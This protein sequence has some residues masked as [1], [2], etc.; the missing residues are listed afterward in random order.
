MTGLKYIHQ[1]T[2]A[3][4]VSTQGIG[5]HSGDAVK[6]SLLPAPA[7]SGVI[8][9]RTDVKNESEAQVFADFRAVSA[10]MLGTTLTNKFGVEVATIEHL[11]AAL[12]GMEIDNVIVEVNSAEMP[13]M[14]GSSA[15]FV[16]MIMRAGVK[17]QDTPRQVLKIMQE[18]RVGDKQKYAKLVPAEE[19]F[20]VRFEIDFDDKAIARQ[21][22]EFAFAANTFVD[23]IA[24]ARTFCM[25]K[26]VDM[27]HAA[28]LARGGSLENA[29][30]VDDGKV[31]NPEG[32]RFTD[33]ALRHK[34]LDSIGDLF[35]AKH[36][37][38]G[39]F[40]GYKSGHK[41]NNEALHTLFDN[42]KAWKLVD[43]VALQPASSEASKLR[44]FAV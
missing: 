19:G 29:V 24:R 6:L 28:G 4:K 16:E 12:W 20:S 9:K 8:F 31:L 21:K 37:I 1:K 34:V 41:I 27:M 14:D 43:E 35:L 26:D 40:I 25:K 2:I 15:P 38:Q 7:N 17:E 11:L 3:K 30:V 42:P 32:L 22:N 10:T 13:I 36:R 18:I 33:E 23:D 5:L 39:G 44:S